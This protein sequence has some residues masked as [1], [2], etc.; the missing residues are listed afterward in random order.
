MVGVRVARGLTK[1]ETK[2]RPNHSCN[3]QKDT[4][5]NHIDFERQ[6]DAS[7]DAKS[8]KGICTVYDLGTGFAPRSKTTSPKIHPRID[9]KQLRKFDAKGFPK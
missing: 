3:L 9:A 7:N 8:F 5:R 1:M 6:H 4:L 2:W